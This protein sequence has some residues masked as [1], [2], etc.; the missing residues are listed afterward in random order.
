MKRMVC[1]MALL[2]LLLAAVSAGGAESAQ[3][4]PYRSTAVI[5]F[6][7]F[8]GGGYDYTAETDDPSIARCETRYEYETNAEEL[9]GASFDFLVTFT[10]MKAGSTT[11]LVRG[12]SPILENEDYLY[13]VEVDEDLQ[14]TLT[15]IQKI[16][17]F[18]ISRN[19][20][21]YYDT[22]RITMEPEGYFISV[23]EGKEKPF[24]EEDA[25]A[26]T[27]VVEKFNIASWDGFSGSR[28]YVL[29]GE[30]FLLEIRFTDGTDVEAM[31]S[32]AFPEHYFDA[33]GNIWEILEK[34]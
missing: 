24:A 5:S 18:F 30:D 8:A 17:E 27:E 13:L 34:Y 25:D 19:G 31:G 22:Y 33:V 29:D 11:A 3:P 9:D 20:E 15:P 26:L 2:M 4:A 21:I 28:K 12:R 7:S 14:V 6:S 1:T 10:G 16:S 23:S 32:N